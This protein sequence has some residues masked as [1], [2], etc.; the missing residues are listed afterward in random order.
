M[1]NPIVSIRIPGSMIEELRE[2]VQNGH[3][4]DVSELVRGIIRQK[5]ME[6]RDPYSYQL[7]KIRKEI[8]DVLKDTISKALMEG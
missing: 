2:M 7:K 4:L 1:A 6:S 5:W 8:S 3:Y